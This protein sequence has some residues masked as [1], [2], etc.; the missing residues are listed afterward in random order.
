MLYKYRLVQLIVRRPNVII[1]KNF[2]NL[3]LIRNVVMTI[4]CKYKI[5]ENFNLNNQDLTKIILNFYK[6]KIEYF[7]I[8][9]R[10]I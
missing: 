6:K 2:I 1:L 10:F 7:S 3:I 9:I 8:K 4:N 5:K